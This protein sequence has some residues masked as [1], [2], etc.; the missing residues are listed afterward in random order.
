M[1]NPATYKVNDKALNNG[2]QTIYSN[3]ITILNKELKEITLN[4]ILEYA[5]QAQG[6]RVY[7]RLDGNTLDTSKPPES[8]IHV[9][10]KDVFLESENYN[11]H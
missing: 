2:K 11:Y 4:N 1:K 10:G 8:I 9:I 6:C 3:S 5:A 7:V